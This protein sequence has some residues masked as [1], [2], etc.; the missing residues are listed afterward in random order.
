M[1]RISF[2]RPCR[3][4]IRATYTIFNRKHAG[5]TPVNMCGFRSNQ[6]IFTGVIVRTY[7]VPYYV[8]EKFNREYQARNQEWI[9]KD[10]TL[11]DQWIHIMFQNDS[12][13]NIQLETR[14]ELANLKWFKCDGPVN[15]YYVL[16]LLKREYY[17]KI[18]CAS[19]KY[20]WNSKLKWKQTRKIH[21]LNLATY[22]RH[23][24]T[25]SLF[26][27]PRRRIRETNTESKKTSSILHRARIYACI[28]ATSYFLIE[29]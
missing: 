1:Y 11:M 26:I 4:N 10:L 3:K 15:P 20:S 12:I 2:E 27:V 21:L 8:S 5:V 29:Y 14:N 6:R 23:E 13:G 18:V 24:S 9:R 19:Y 28:A 22:V 25:S 7:Y 16:Q 17:G